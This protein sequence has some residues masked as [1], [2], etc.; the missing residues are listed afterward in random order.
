VIFPLSH[1]TTRSEASAEDLMRWTAGRVLVATG[2]PYAR[3][4]YEG[5]TIPIAQCNNV[6]NDQVA[7]MQWTPQYRGI[8]LAG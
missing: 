2:S 6:F 1:P 4:R 5:R 3:V 7:A 8:V